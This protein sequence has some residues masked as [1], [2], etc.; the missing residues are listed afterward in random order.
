MGVWSDGWPG[1]V[2]G[3]AE[4]DGKYSVDFI[5]AGTFKVAVVDPATCSRR[6]DGQFAA[7]N[8]RRLSDVVGITLFEITACNQGGS[9][10]R[11][12][13]HFRGP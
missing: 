1:V 13:V 10:Q 8:C 3:P 12:E 6:D 2:S 9:V 7:S 5:A 11:A 4:P